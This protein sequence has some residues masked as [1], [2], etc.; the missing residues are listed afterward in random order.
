[1]R[2]RMATKHFNRT[3]K[4]RTAMRRNMAAALIQ[5]GSIRTTEAKAKHL[6]RFVEKLITVAKKGTLH[7]RRQVVSRLQD[8]D[9]YTY[10]AKNNDYDIEEQTVVQKLFDVIAPR[11]ADRPGGYTRIIHLAER[12]I[13]DAGKQVILQLIEDEPSRGGLGG[14][15]RRS[16]RAAR[17]IEAAEGIEERTEAPAEEAPEAV[18]EAP[19]EAPAEEAPAEE[20]P[21][22]E[23]PAEEAPAEEAP[24]EEAPAEEAPAEEAPAEEAPA[25]E[26]KDKE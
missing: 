4:H 11:Y 17:R 24:A 6:R 2:H 25:E 23:A 13:G 8:R 22:E 14:D 15:S 5:H 9:M 26:E 20:A 7:A 1:M 10:D 3:S 16:A 12:R 21:A 18:E 19:A